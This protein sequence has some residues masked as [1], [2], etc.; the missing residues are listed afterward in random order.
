MKSKIIEIDWIDSSASLGWAEPLPSAPET[1]T[2]KSIGFLIC[3]DKDTL[4]MSAHMV[5]S[6]RYCHSP[7]TIPKCAIRKRKVIGIRD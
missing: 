2:V 1:M 5:Q 7:M 3:E 4:T 6:K